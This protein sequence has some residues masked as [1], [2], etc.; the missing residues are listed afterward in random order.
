MSMADTIA[1]MNGG[2]I[3]QAGSATDLYERPQ[4]AFVAN[5]LGISNLID[6]QGRRRPS[7][8]ETHDGAELHVPECAGRTGDV[9]VGVRPEKITLRPGRRARPGR[10]AT[11]CAAR[12]SSPRSSASR[13]S[14]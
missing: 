12:S 2:K 7:S 4:T 6:A 3:E 5:F 8:V 9:R 14:T 10:L 13:S 1:V 11:S